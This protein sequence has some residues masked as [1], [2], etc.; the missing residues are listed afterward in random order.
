M[1]RFKY[2]KEGWL[3]AAC[4]KFF[5]NATNLLVRQEDAILIQLNERILALTPVWEG[6]ALIQCRPTTRSCRDTGSHTR[7]Q[8]HQE[9]GVNPHA[10][11]Y[12]RHASIA[13]GRAV[14]RDRPVART[15]EHDNDPSICRGRPGDEGEGA[16]TAGGVRHQDGPL[17]GAG[18]ALAIPENAV[19]MRRPRRAE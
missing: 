13:V 15:R 4:D 1:A 18:L 19:T 16:R 10:A 2:S 11:T 3:T 17:Q 6:D 9:A 12:E 7:A 8:S 5:Q 14:Q